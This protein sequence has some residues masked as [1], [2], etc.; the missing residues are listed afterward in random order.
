VSTPSPDYPAAL[1]ATR[2]TFTRRAAR[3]RNL[4]VAVVLIG[5]VAPVAAVVLW[6]WRPLLGWL[7]VVP[8]SAAFF[9]LDARSVARWR[10]ALLDGWAAGTLS[11]DS[12]RDGLTAIRQLPPATL[13]AMLAPLPTRARLDRSA[14]LSS[15]T[16]EAV[17]ATVRAIDAAVVRRTA[18]AA[19]AVAVGAAG[20]AAAAAAGSWWP[21]AG[22]PVALALNLVARRIGSRPPR[23][24]VRRVRDLR[25]RGLDAAAFAELAG[26]LDWSPLPAGARDR[27]LARLDRPDTAPTE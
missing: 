16:R 3:Y 11:L 17:A 8:V 12:L 15:E 19:I 2:E 10:A 7:L 20:L 4:V 14:D 5:F 13:A 21:L 24:W 1:A 26:R 18:L 25:G 23:G 27:W 22:L 6:S 9:A